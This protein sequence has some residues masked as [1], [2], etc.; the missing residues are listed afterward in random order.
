MM[1][2]PSRFDSPLRSEHG[3]AGERSAVG[4]KN[5]AQTAESELT[6]A[7]SCKD[8][9]MHPGKRCVPSQSVERLDHRVFG[10][11][12]R[13]G[14]LGHVRTVSSFRYDELT[15]ILHPR[16]QALNLFSSFSFF[17]LDPLR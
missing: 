17:L 13:S 8:Q 3:H 12:D 4:V 10:L 7:G 9:I 16:L 2:E 6:S 11:S 14:S 1:A 5:D 15:E